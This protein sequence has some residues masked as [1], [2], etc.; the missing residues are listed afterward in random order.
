MK[1]PF[2]IATG[3]VCWLG[4]GYGNYVLAEDLDSALEKINISTEAQNAPKKTDKVSVP[5]AKATTVNC[6][7][8]LQ[9]DVNKNA[10]EASAIEG[11]ITGGVIPSVT[12]NGVSIGELP[13]KGA[14]SVGGF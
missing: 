12:I 10:Y 9:D 7:N 1:T 14:V 8:A 13:N 11:A 6:P 3:I 2:V 5:C 4:G